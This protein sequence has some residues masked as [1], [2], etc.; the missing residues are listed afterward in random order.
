MGS[1][2][3]KLL[4]P[5]IGLSNPSDL[6]EQPLFH[7]TLKTTENNRKK[8]SHGELIPPSM[9]APKPG[10]QNPEKL[11]NLVRDKFAK[12]REFV[13]GKLENKMQ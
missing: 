12:K 9:I 10:L 11:Q 5:N 4:A 13:E 6:S 8:I 2:D 3:A 7:F 1:S